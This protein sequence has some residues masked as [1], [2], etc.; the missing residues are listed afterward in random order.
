MADVVTPT[1]C[2][3]IDLYESLDFCDGKTVL[4]GI[5]P[6]VFFQ[7]KSNIVTWPKL[8]DL[9]DAKSMGSLAT[10]AGNFVLAADKKWLTLKSLSTKSNV[11]SEV[12]G[13]KPSRTTLNKC[14]L[15]HPGTEEEAAGFC[16][17]ATADDLVYLVQQRNGKFRVM[18]CEEFETDTKPAQALGEGITGEAG[19]TL[20]IE[21]TDLCPAPFYPGK[22]ETEDGDISGADGTAWVDPE[23]APASGN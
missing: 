7:K 2:N 12:Q 23:P 1:G 4:P 14:T 20:E 13:E 15:K 10:Y 16:R 9:E 8:P 17:Q 21:A 11:T 5:R 3:A 6:K 22:I 19:T 18:G